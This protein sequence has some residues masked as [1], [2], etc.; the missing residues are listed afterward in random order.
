MRIAIG[1]A[2]SAS[3]GTLLLVNLLS[4]PFLALLGYGIP[5]GLCAGLFAEWLS[6]GEPEGQVNAYSRLP[7]PAPLG[8]LKAN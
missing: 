5:F 3:L 1:A 7:S 2:V 6:E 8:E 4:S